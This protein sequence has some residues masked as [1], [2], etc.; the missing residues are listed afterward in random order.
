MLKMLLC[1]EGKTDHGFDTY[2]DGE[3]DH[4]DGVIQVFLQKLA[5]EETLCFVIRKRGDIKRFALIPNPNKFAPRNLVTGRKLA[6]IAQKEE[7]VC[8]AYHRDEDNKGFENV[9]SQIRG[10]FSVDDMNALFP[11]II[12]NEEEAN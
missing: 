4:T 2:H 1:C 10:Y 6:A 3:V 12:H 7:C 8:I 11:G 9:Y 5:S